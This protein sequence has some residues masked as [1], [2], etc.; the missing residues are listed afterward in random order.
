M[1]LY[2]LLLRLYPASFR[3]EYGGEM[4]AVL[5]RRWRDANP[6]ARILIVF[7]AV[8]DVVVNAA[9]VHA[10][11]TVQ[12]VRY[13]VRTLLR[14]RSFT[15]TAVLVAAIGIG[16]TTAV[17]SITDH[18]LIR[19][20]PFKDPDR[21][22]RL[23]QDQSFRGY[24]QMELS[25]ANF[26][27]WQRMATGFESMGA[28]SPWS[29]NLTGQGNPERVVGASVT[30]E[31]LPMLGVAPALG[32]VFTTE[33][34]RAAV[35]GTVL[36]S[37]GLW[38]ERF[39]GAPD[40]IGRK[41][42]LNDE[43]Y[44]VIGVMPREFYFP[45]RAIRFWRAMRLGPDDLENRTNWYLNGIARLRDG[46]S[47]EESRAQ[48]RAVAA[49]LA[50]Q[51][52]AE[53]AHNSATVVDMRSD[54]SQQS[55][56]LLMAL[57]GAA[58][59]VLLIACTNL[60]NLLLARAITRRR[61]L[62]V[63]AALGAGRERLVR[64]M[65]TESLLLALSGGAL[66][67]A[68]AVAAMPVAA[69]LVPHGLPIAETPAFD[70]RVLIFGA[71]VTVAT[72]IGFGM[73]PALRAGQLDSH[74]LSE[75]TRAGSSRRASRLRS[76]LV[77]AEVTASVVLLIS[78]GLLIRALWSLQHVD[79]GFDARGVLTLRTP[80]PL[81][82]Y[83]ATDVRARFYERV[84][85]DIR[86]LPGVT[87]AAYISSVPMGWLRGG[88]WPVTMDGRR[89]SEVEAR[90]A[91]IRFV[92]PGLFQALR[93]PL[94]AGRDVSERDTREAPIVAVVSESF[95]RHYWPGESPLGRRFF[96]A[97][98]ERIVVGV[99]GDVRVRGLE[100]P[101]EPQVYLPYQ[102]V[103][104]GGL[105]GYTP[106][107]L[108]VRSSTSPLAVLP[109]IRSIIARADPQLPL[110]DIRLL[111]DIIDGETAPRT[112]QL[113]VLV[114]FAAVALLLAGIGLHGL[115]AFMVSTQTREIGVRIALGAP[116][117]D[118]AALVV[119][120]GVV[121]AMVGA[122]LGVAL[123]YGAGRTMEALLAGVSPSD[124]LAYS[125]AVGLVLVV[126]LAGTL[127]PAVRA[128]RIDPLTA[129]RTE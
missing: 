61:E 34:D 56:L 65:L 76:L 79:P 14:A 86:G 96:F 17:F 4:A 51:F 12:D 115:L 102:Q 127:V 87:H 118:I 1:R 60:G 37:H 27:D 83:A 106:Q 30:S 107:D 8:A 119:R 75:G 121:L 122:A 124:P 71:A 28:F 69:Q 78:A 99:V 55:R 84:L 57:F 93:I 90:T 82:K 22:V 108:V 62:A 95:A 59:C 112:V 44:E 19:P 94:R 32:R 116:S 120:H 13:S 113:R 47:V 25:P 3:N 48:L 104:D 128:M 39:G 42:I 15:V 70:A 110:F 81:P 58:G 105:Q 72:A 11:L 88:I 43:P 21:L 85:S 29:A 67:I 38:H 26:R 23:Y 54:L 129:I 18:V 100:R 52:P 5:A 33:E 7:D 98:L 49:E 68:I 2:R 10:E 89:E 36:L 123:A 63:R 20:L 97:F 101:S 40:I 50:R 9:R 126:T 73:L 35:T 91:S 125:A 77:V 53:N 31:V 111:Q 92:T 46:V 6:G 117:R 16:A 103:P 66:G 114:A 109:A 80:L 41:I 24:R 64:Q 45:R 74:A